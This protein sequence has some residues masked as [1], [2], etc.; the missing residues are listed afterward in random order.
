MNDIHEDEAISID[1]IESF[2]FNNQLVKMKDQELFELDKDLKFE[3]R[4]RS[5][6][7]T[8]LLSAYK[9]H[10]LHT[11]T[12]KNRARVISFCIFC[13]LLIGSAYLLKNVIVNITHL[14]YFSYSDLIAVI[15]SSTSFISVIFVIP[16]IMIKF[17][18]NTK[19]DEYIT[20]IIKNTQDFDK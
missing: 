14:D 13:I 18:F 5:K 11:I 17:I 8:E 2:V 15:S 20:Q 9:Q 19:E 16:K 1:S 7:Y 3:K 6:Q 12:F 10:I 4:N